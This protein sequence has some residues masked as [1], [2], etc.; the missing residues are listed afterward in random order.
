[1]TDTAANAILLF[2]ASLKTFTTLGDTGSAGH[3]G[4]LLPFGRDS[5]ALVDRVA[6][7][8][9]IVGP[10]GRFG[11]VIAP[12]RPADMQFYSGAGN[13][14]PGFDSSGR[15]FYR[16][17]V[18]PPNTIQL[19]N[20]AARDTTVTLPDSAPI[21]RA[22]LEK[23]RLDTV[24]M[25]RVPSD[26]RRARSESGQLRLTSFLNPLPV[27]DEWALYPDGT[28]AVARG[29][30]YHIDWFSPDGKKVSSPP[31]AFDWLRLT[32]G[33][34]KRIVDSVQRMVDSVWGQTV[35]RVT[36]AARARTLAGLRLQVVSASD[37]PD[38]VPAVKPG[39]PIRVD[40]R[41]RLWIVPATSLLHPDGT[42]FDI[43][44]REGR[45]VERVQLPAGRVLNA[46]GGGDTLFLSVPSPRFTRIEKAVVTR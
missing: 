9:V 46:F 11:R 35:S 27:I 30:D 17:A 39:S 5:A 21:L 1:M 44:S 20:V 10:D 15:L 41:G 16:G 8:L 7:A 4:G 31:M 22:D 24:A 23:R 29:R 18:G 25:V 13:G 3:A 28:V 36:S 2:D 33:D 45:V 37:L 40:P 6:R 42:V 14:A 43:V 12:L 38:Y 34:K 32:D 26:R 19:D